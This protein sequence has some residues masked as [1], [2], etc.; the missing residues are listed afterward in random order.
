MTENK[1]SVF[2]DCVVCHQ[3]SSDDVADFN[4]FIE[5]SCKK[6]SLS[7]LMKSSLEYSDLL[8]NRKL[9]D[10]MK[11]INSKHTKYDF[12][13]DDIRKH[14]IF[15][16]GTRNASLRQSLCNSKAMQMLLDSETVSQ[17]STAIKLLQ[18]NQQSAR[19][20]ASEN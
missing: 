18:T 4:D 6:T 16:I 15:C 2:C 20:A 10:N 5:D 1:G 17:T 19:V 8:K 11:S 7:M 12:T 14:V 13:E 9:S 3:M